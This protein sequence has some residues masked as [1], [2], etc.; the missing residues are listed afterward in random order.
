MKLLLIGVVVVL[1]VL[2]GV[3]I[4]HAQSPLAAPTATPTYGAYTTWPPLFP[5]GMVTTATPT[6][7]PPTVTPTRTPTPY[8]LIYVIP[9]TSTPTPIVTPATWLDTFQDYLTRCIAEASGPSGS[10]TVAVVGACSL[11]D[12]YILDGYVTEGIAYHIATAACRPAL[13]YEFAVLACQ[14]RADFL[15]RMGYANGFTLLSRQRCLQMTYTI[16]NLCTKLGILPPIGAIG[17]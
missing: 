6:S 2:A 9:P 1:A 16:C 14:D 3:S 11:L 5:P 10:S 7:L 8:T 12:H 17:F 15:C 4:G 13:T